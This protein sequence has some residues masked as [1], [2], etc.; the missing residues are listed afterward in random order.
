M[1]LNL[2]GKRAKQHERLAQLRLREVQAR[3]L[4]RDLNKE[5]NRLGSRVA[6]YYAAGLGEGTALDAV[7]GFQEAGALILVRHLRKTGDLFGSR[8]LDALGKSQRLRLETKS[9]TDAFKKAFDEWL[10]VYSAQQIAKISSTT[11]KVIRG[12]IAA[13]ARDGLSLD[14]VAKNMRLKLGGRFSRYRAHVIARTETH[15]AANKGAMAAAEATN[16]T[17]YKEWVASG[18][19]SRDAHAAASG[20]IRRQNEA[21]NVG[22]ALMQQPGDP[23]GGAENVIEC[24]CVVIFTTE[25]PIGTF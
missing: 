20:Q 6:K 18:T 23:A 2:R 3:L 21:F 12:V 4:E 15:V 5:F 11:R 10:G 1:P 7:L 8:L 9:D 25:A 16:L 19:R 22:G 13:G 17:L 14:Q 24:R